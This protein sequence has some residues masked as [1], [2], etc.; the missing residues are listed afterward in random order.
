[1]R[2]MG[3]RTWLA[4]ALMAGMVW[5]LMGCSRTGET[6]VEPAA[7]A[8]SAQTDGLKSLGLQSYWE[9]SAVMTSTERVAK[10]FLRDENLYLLTSQNNLYAVDAAVGNPKWATSVSATNE[11]VYAPTHFDGMML[12]REVPPQSSFKNPPSRTTFDTFD[13]VLINTLNRILVIDR[14]SGTVYRN[15]AMNN[16]AAATRG[17][18]DGQNYFFGSVENFYYCVTLLQAVPLWWFPM[19]MPIS[20]PVSYFNEDLYIG[21]MTGAL[22]RASAITGGRQWQVNLSGSIRHEMLVDASGL[23]LA[24]GDGRIYGLDEETGM[25]LWEP[26]QTTG[27]IETAPQKTDRTLF[28]ASRG[29]GFYAI[30]IASGSIRWKLKGGKKIVAVMGQDVYVMDDGGTIIPINE[31][32]GEAGESFRLGKALLAANTAVDAIYAVTPEGKIFCIRAEDVSP[33]TLE[34][35]QQ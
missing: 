22:R 33:L 24:T 3:K 13:A 30:D 25:T 19:D 4:T 32:T 7:E 8:P 23:F 5:T 18:T 10:V 9:R 34:M 26:I 15:F 17:V 14:D 35:L 29:D 28:Q 27:L 2:S 6:Q 1:M 12:P 16:A 20:A 11:H 31:I 21:T